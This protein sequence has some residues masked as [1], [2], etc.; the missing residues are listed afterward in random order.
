MSILKADKMSPLFKELIVASSM[1]QFQKMGAKYYLSIDTSSVCVGS[2]VWTPQ[3]CKVEPFFAKIQ[4]A[5][6]WTLFSSAEN[7][8]RHTCFQNA[9]IQ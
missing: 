1:A 5:E 6:K 9:V 4:M 7:L 3:A 8:F 2:L